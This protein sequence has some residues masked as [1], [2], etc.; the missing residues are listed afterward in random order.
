MFVTEDCWLLLYPIP[1]ADH[2]ELLMISRNGKVISCCQCSCVLD[3]MLSLKEH[4]QIDWSNHCIRFW[5]ELLII[6]IHVLGSECRSWVLFYSLP[7]LLDILPMEHL[8][9]Y[10]LLVASIHMLL[11]DRI[12]VSAIDVVKN[13]LQRFYHDYESIYGNQPQWD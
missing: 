13:W 12:P 7:V 6:C 8:S 5:V 10:A 2:H 3:M 1:L 4:S 9:H 11:S